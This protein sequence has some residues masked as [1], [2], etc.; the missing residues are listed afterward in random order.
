MH[1]KHCTAL[2]ALPS[3]NIL[4]LEELAFP[5]GSHF[6]VENTTRLRDGS[7]R[8]QKKGYEEVFVP[9][10]KPMPFAEGE[11]CGVVWCGVVWCGVVWCGVV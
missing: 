4:D 9:E 8:K 2:Q 6:M 10:P 11:V 3:T 7:H 5:Q 1:S